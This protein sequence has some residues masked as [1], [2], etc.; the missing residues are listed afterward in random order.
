MH[1]ATAKSP[2]QADSVKEN[3]HVRFYRAPARSMT[4]TTCTVEDCAAPKHGLLYCNT[5]YRRWKKYGDPLQARPTP[6]PP[7]PV[8][9]CSIEGCDRPV[10]IKSRG[11]CSPHYSRWRDHGD[12]LG[13]GP[14]RS[15]VP[16]TTR[17]CAVD[18]CTRMAKTKGYCGSHYYREWRHGDPT[19][20]RTPEGEALA[21]FEAHINDET[22][23]CMI[24]PYGRTDFGHG[25]VYIDGRYTY[26]S[27]LACERAHGPRPSPQHLACHG[28]CHNPACWNPRHVEWSTQNQLHRVRDG[29]DLRGEQIAQAKLTEADVRAI[30][31]RRD[32]GESLVGLAKEYGIHPEHAGLIAR[33]V[34]TWLHVVD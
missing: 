26:A 10:R 13:G 3:R 30:R 34:R 6:P 18:G 31:R 33:R 19:A 1:R 20:G 12:P 28:A 22:D 7:A 23:E 27:T 17:E 15:E 14:D 11:W 29:T 8:A 32:A 25:R 16:Q 9:T 21:Y 4:D 2:V 24:W 5:H